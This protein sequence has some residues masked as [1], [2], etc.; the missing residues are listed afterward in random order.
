MTATVTR[1]VIDAL[2]RTPGQALA[3]PTEGIVA[4]ILIVVLI[5]RVLLAAAAPAVDEAERI[6]TPDPD[7]WSHLRLR[8]DW[9]DESP[10]ALLAA[11]PDLE[12]LEPVELRGRIAELASRIVGRY[13]ASVRDGVP[14]R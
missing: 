5:T 9:P 10:G 11:G 13:D 1:F 7:G 8:L 4:V 14:P 2:P 12:V 6:D 3:T